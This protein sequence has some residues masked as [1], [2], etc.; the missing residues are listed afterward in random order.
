MIPADGSHCVQYERGSGALPRRPV[1]A[2]DDE[3]A[4]LVVGRRGLV[5]AFELGAVQRIVRDQHPAVAAVPGGG[6]LIDCK[7]DDG[8]TW[9]L[10]ILAWTVH[11]DGSTTPLTT[12]ADGVTSD[13]TEGLAEYRIYHPD[14]KL[15]PGEPASK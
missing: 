9:T 11:A 3:G 15:P 12:D 2:W 1:V 5:P 14:E 7:D 8:I 4:P 6:W 10:P 13:A